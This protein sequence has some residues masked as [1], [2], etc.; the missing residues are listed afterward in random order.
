MISGREDVHGISKLQAKH[1]I[2]EIR[3]LSHIV[4][5]I[6]FPKTGRFDLDP[7]RVIG[8]MDCII[9]SQQLNLP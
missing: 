2:V 1:L 4:A 5:R 7:N 8:I 3:V 9:Q 6:I